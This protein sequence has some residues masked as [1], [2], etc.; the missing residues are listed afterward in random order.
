MGCLS[1]LPKGY[2]GRKQQCWDLAQIFLVQQLTLLLLLGVKRQMCE[3]NRC[4]RNK[5][6]NSVL[7][8]CPK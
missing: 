5:I 7:F 3:K 8:Q 1:N 2:Q 4:H 6:I